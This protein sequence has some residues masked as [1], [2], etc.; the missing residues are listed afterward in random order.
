LGI[1]LCALQLV[2][3]WA[4]LELSSLYATTIG[5]KEKDGVRVHFPYRGQFDVSGPVNAKMHATRLIAPDKRPLRDLES[6]QFKLVEF[7]KRFVDVVFK[8]NQ[9]AGQ[10]FGIRHYDL[11]QGLWNTIFSVSDDWRR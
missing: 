3:G 1:R 7:A 8:L 9:F 4:G 10:I 6:S 5:A 2:E 11:P